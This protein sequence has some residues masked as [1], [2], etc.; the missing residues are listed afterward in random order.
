MNLHSGD[1]FNVHITYDGTTLTMTITDANTP[2]DTFTTS[3]TVN[4]PGT[5]GANTAY[6]GFTGGTGGADRDPG[7]P[8]LDLYVR[9]ARAIQYEATKIPVTGSPNARSF[10]WTGFPDG[11]GEIA[12][13]TAAG[14]YLNFTVNV[15]TPGNLR[16][17]SCNQKVPH[18]RNLSTLRQRCQRRT[19]GGRIQR[20]SGTA[21][22]RSTISATL[23]FTSAGNYSFKFTVTGHNSSSSGYTV[24]FDYI[25]L[26]PQ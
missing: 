3:W 26:T 20:Q 5:V 10:A 13:G 18:P 9:C 16:H 23:T 2:A 8:D 15:A 19:N 14:A 24:C 6:A 12:D 25:K 17:Q 1:V 22:S 7:H 21:Y 11:A 4:I